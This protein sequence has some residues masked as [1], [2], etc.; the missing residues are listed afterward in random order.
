MALALAGCSAGEQV[1]VPAPDAA[2]PRDVTT[3]ADVARMSFDV[4]PLDVTSRGDDAAT[5]AAPVEEDVSREQFCMGAGPPVV[6]GDRITRST[7]CVGRIAEAVFR[8]AICTCNDVALA[9]YLYTDSFD[10]GRDG[11]M[12]G[13]RGGAVGVN[14]TYGLVGATR[15]GDALTIAGSGPLRLIGA[16]TVRGDLSL[17]GN[18]EV[19]GTLDVERN[20]RIRGSLLAIGPFH[21]QGDLTTPPGTLPLGV[22]RVDGSRRSGA[23]DVAPPCACRDDEIFDVGAGVTDA[24]RNN[25]NAAVGLRSGVLSAVVGEQRLDLPCGRFYLDGIA[26]LGSITLNVPGRTALFVGGDFNLGGYFNVALG[27]MGELDVFIAGSITGA[28]YLRMGRV[29]RPS[30]VRF[31]IAGNRGFTLAGAAGFQGNVYAPRAPVT[32]AGFN[33]MRGSL[34][35]SRVITGGDL[36]IHYDRSVLRAGDDCPDTPTPGGCTGCG[37]GT[38]RATQA[39]VMGACGM[40]RSDADCCAPTVCETRTGQCLPLPP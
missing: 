30:R 40:C 36:T 23:V 9:G 11:S 20:A 1:D 10:S 21:V 8:H 6:V 19:A 33:E 31:Y 5:D 13:E 15:I 22:I 39:C 37:A 27:P 24:S 35:A 3:T 17:Q 18:L 28:G 26:G 29:S 25:D 14:G 38:C 4:A 16:H 2:A 12:S 32:I 34:F 7:R